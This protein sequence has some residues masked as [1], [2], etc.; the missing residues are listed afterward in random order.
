MGVWRWGLLSTHT[1]LD[2]I[3]EEAWAHGCDPVS[4]VKV[5]WHGQSFGA[6]GL[7]FLCSGYHYGVEVEQKATAGAAWG[8]EGGTGTDGSPRHT[9]S[10]LVI[11]GWRRLDLNTSAG[12]S[13]PPQPL[14]Y[15]ALGERGAGFCW[16]VSFQ[17]TSQSPQVVP[18]VWEEMGSWIT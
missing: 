14:R 7:S 16:G 13:R 10:V 1:H 5:G 11:N 12:D 17:V 15:L 2:L 9:F 3:T 6:G 4:K 8:G 18:G